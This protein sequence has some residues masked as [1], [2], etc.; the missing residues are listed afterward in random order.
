[1]EDIKI[2]NS[3]EIPEELRDKKP[4]E[5]SENGD[6]IIKEILKRRNRHERLPEED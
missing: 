6:E 1:M 2:D 4:P 3:D 5:Y